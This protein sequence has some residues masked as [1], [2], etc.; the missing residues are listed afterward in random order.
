M[1]VPPPPT[2]LSD[3]KSRPKCP[4]G[5]RRSCCKDCGGGEICIHGRWR[6]I[7]KDCKGSQIC[8]HGREKRVCIE[9]DGTGICDHGRQKAQCKDCK[10]SNYCEH[11]KQRQACA[12]CTNFVCDIASCTLLGH[13]FAGVRSLQRHMQI[14][15]TDNPKA[16]TKSKELDV[17]QALQRAGIEFEYQKYLPFRSCGLASETAYAYIDFCIQ[18]HWGVILLECDEEQHSA[19]D[20]SC[21]VRRDFDSCASITLGSQHKAVVLRYNPDAFQIGGK[22]KYTLKKQRQAKL[23]ETVESWEEDPAPELGFARFF[24]FYDA[25]NDASPLPC[26]AHGWSK[27]VCA[28]SRRIC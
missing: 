12:E 19:Y 23:V 14:R 2:P 3:V 18:K 6:L 10:G 5:L 22:T 26:I 1:D 15:H 8:D 20:S 13:R 17:H 25:E 24:M 27:E 21:D 28:V 16:L 9:C 4:H 11:G 7:C